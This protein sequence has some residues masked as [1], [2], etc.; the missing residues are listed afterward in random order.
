MSDFDFGLS[1]ISTRGIT[2]GPFVPLFGTDV[3]SSTQGLSIMNPTNYASPYAVFGT[4]Y[5]SITHSDSFVNPF[6]SQLSRYETP[7][8]EMQD[9]SVPQESFPTTTREWSNPFQDEDQGM[10][11]DTSSAMKNSVLPPSGTK[12]PTIPEE[13][14]GATAW[15]YNMVEPRLKDQAVDLDHLSLYDETLP[16]YS[17]RNS[18]MSAATDSTIVKGADEAAEASEAI[19]AVTDTAEAVE[20][21]ATGG[22]G[23]ALMASQMAAQGVN[24]YLTA[25]VEQGITGQYQSNARSPGLNSGLNAS[26]IAQ[27]NMQNAKMIDAGGSIG[28][29]LGPLGMLAGRSIASSFTSDISFNTLDTAYSAYGRIN[30]QTDN[31]NITQSSLGVSNEN[32]AS[33]SQMS[34]ATSSQDTSS[35]NDGNSAN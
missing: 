6:A 2:P 18:A 1:L 25:D 32:F 13:N 24:S 15:D 30:P 34:A 10:F 9:F 4:N 31:V 33:G 5:N 14:T 3:G 11:G 29:L 22:A 23:A 7:G 20:T 26:L 16:P 8:I 21:G 19:E 35:I 28:S 27:H 12:L 17:G